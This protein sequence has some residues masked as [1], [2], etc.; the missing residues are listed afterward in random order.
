MNTLS[1]VFQYFVVHLLF[2]IV[3]TINQLTPFSTAAEVAALASGQAADKPGS[4]QRTTKQTVRR[5]EQIVAACVQTVALCP[6]LAILFIAVRMRAG[7]LAPNGVASPPDYAQTAMFWCSSLVLADTVLAAVLA[8]FTLRELED[9]MEDMAS[10][11]QTQMGGREEDL[12]DSANQTMVQRVQTAMTKAREDATD[13]AEDRFGLGDINNNRGALDRARGAR[14]RRLRERL[15]AERWKAFPR[16][17]GFLRALITFGIYAATVILIEALL[18]MEAASGSVNC[19][20]CPWSYT[21]ALPPALQGVINLVAQF[22]ALYLLIYAAELHEKLFLESEDHAALQY[23]GSPGA[24]RAT[25]QQALVSPTGRGGGYH[26]PGAPRQSFF[27]TVVEGAKPTVNLC[28]M[29]AVLF[30]GFRLRAQQLKVEPQEFVQVCFLVTSL[31]ILSQTVL[32][33]VQPTVREYRY[34]T[35]VF[36]LLKYALLAGL[37]VGT[38]II[39]VGLHTVEAPVHLGRTR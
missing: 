8:A 22:F 37:Y 27:K 25:S 28:P 23:P 38:A 39:I 18:S 31:S 12:E 4:K 17:V 5:W 1:L 29:L 10:W 19:P 6:M 14:D 20:S 30:M 11:M 15:A 7:A 35:P 9:E 16:I 24:R 34:L 33:L 26:G 21:P 32:A 2:Q 36:H 13:W 3:K